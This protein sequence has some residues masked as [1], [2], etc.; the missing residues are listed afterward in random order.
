MKFYL[1]DCE[2]QDIQLDPTKISNQLEMAKVLEKGN[3]LFGFYLKSD[4][5]LEMLKKMQAI[6]EN[7][8]VL[9]EEAIIEGARATATI[10]GVPMSDTYVKEALEINK[11]QAVK[12]DTDM[13]YDEFLLCYNKNKYLP[14]SCYHVEVV[15]KEIAE[16]NDMNWITGTPELSEEDRK[17]YKVGEILSDYRKLGDSGYYFKF[18]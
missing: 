7:L 2:H 12:V 14:N 4:E 17:N 8:K 11:V 13:A 10:D 1:S 9:K 6:T 5:V 3:N 15:T 18:M 16:E